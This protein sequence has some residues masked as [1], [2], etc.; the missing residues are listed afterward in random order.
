MNKII[1]SLSKLL[2]NRGKEIQNILHSFFFETWSSQRFI[3]F[4]FFFKLAIISIFSISIVII[5]TVKKIRRI[6]RDSIIRIGES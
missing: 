2:K 4:Y 6:R 5:N 3:L 1:A